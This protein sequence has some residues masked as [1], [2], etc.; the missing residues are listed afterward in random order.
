MLK[1][2]IKYLKDN[3]FLSYDFEDDFSN[4]NYLIFPDIDEDEQKQDYD[5]K[6]MEIFSKDN[7]DT[8]HNS[9]VY[10]SF[11]TE[12]SKSS[13]ANR[14]SIMN[15]PS[16]IVMINTLTSDNIVKEIPFDSGMIWFVSKTVKINEK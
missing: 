9:E 4:D 11:K 14:N 7:T 6:L 10:F 3:G 12:N 2:K 1:N 15:V 5:K 13:L 16:D 8:I